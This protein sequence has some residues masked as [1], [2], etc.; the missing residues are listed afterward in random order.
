MLAVGSKI[1]NA[2]IVRTYRK[3][4]LVIDY[5]NGTDGESSQIWFDSVDMCCVDCSLIKNTE[6]K[7]LAI[8]QVSYNLYLEFV[9]DAG[10]ISILTLQPDNSRWLL[11]QGIR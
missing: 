11:K 7:A 4:S 3:P 10:E 5:D 8:Q 1:I 9:N 2:E 6:V